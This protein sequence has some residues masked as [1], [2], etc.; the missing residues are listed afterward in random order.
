MKIT[1]LIKN[2]LIK[3][4]MLIKRPRHRIFD[5]TPRHYEPENDDR[6]LRKKKLRFRYTKNIKKKKKPLIFWILFL[7]FILYLYLR[8]AGYIH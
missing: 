7:A 4:L 6:E 5:Y 1:I 8:L 3:N 2:I